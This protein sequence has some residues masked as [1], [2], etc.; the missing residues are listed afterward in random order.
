MNVYNII[1]E[2]FF[3]LLKPWWTMIIKNVSLLWS[4]GSINYERSLSDCTPV[5]RWNLTLT[6]K[7]EF[8][9]SF[10]IHCCFS[11]WGFHIMVTHR[12]WR[13]VK[14]KKRPKKSLLAKLSDLMWGF[15]ISKSGHTVLKIEVLFSHLSSWENHFQWSKVVSEA[16]CPTN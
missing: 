5:R 4:N 3:L 16:I 15:R 2:H 14:S 11:L 12:S 7:P 9:L 13:H 10:K 1:G 8:G 6:L